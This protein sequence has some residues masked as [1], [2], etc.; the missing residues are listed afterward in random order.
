MHVAR[1]ASEFSPIEF[2]IAS[3]TVRLILPLELCALA[4]VRHLDRLHSVEICGARNS[5]ICLARDSTFVKILDR[6]KGVS[7]IDVGIPPKCC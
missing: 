7:R 2:G 5:I 3:K 6:V 1:S 4:N